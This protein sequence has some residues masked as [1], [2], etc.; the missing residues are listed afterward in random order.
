MTFNFALDRAIEHCREMG[1]PLMIFEALRCE[2]EWASDRMHRFVIDG[3]ADNAAS[4]KRGP[5]RPIYGQIR[6]I[7][8]ENTARKISVQKYIAKYAPTGNA[9]VKTQHRYGGNGV[10]EEKWRKRGEDALGNTKRST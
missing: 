8:S 3:M 9:G 6:Y 1:K 5:G 4:C 2:Y 7:T 10:R